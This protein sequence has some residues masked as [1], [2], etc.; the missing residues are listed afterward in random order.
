MSEK[1]IRK[2]CSSV[3]KH[4][5]VLFAAAML[6]LSNLF[7]P[8]QA[9][10]DTVTTSDNL[11]GDLGGTV[12][13]TH[14][15]GIDNGQFWF[16]GAWHDL[17]EITPGGLTQEGP[18]KDLG[19]GW[20]IYYSPTLWEDGGFMVWRYHT[21]TYDGTEWNNPPLKF[22]F[23][24]VGHTAFGEKFDV[25]ISFDSVHAWKQRAHN[26]S[27]FSPFSIT[28]KYG[29]M[30]AAQ[31]ND[32]MG[33]KS[34]FTTQLVQHG[35]NTLINPNNEFNLM[36]WDIDQPVWNDNGSADYSSEWREGVHKV[37]GYKP[38][39]II[40]TD[41]QLAVTD[42]ATWFRSTRDD[43]SNVPTSKSTVIMK[44]NPQYTTEWRGYG[45]LTCLGYDSKV[46]VYPEWSDPVKSEEE[47]IKE[48]GE[49][50]TFDITQVFPYVSETNK[51]QSIVMTDMLDPALD[52]SQA[53]VEVYKDNINVT[54]N[55]TINISGQTV[56][57]TAKNT[58]HGYTE[59]KHI[60]RLTVPVSTTADISAYPLYGEYYKVPNQASVS[61]NN[62]TKQTNEVRVLVPLKV[63]G[64]VTIAAKKKLTGGV[65]LQQDQFS[66]T[67]T[68][69][70]GSVVGR[71][72]NNANGDISFAPLEFTRA[73]IGKTYRYVI[74][75]DQGSQEGI[76]YDTHKE[77]VSVSITD[78]GH[79]RV[80]V[81]AHYDADGAVF[82]NVFHTTQLGIL[83]QSSAADHKVLANAKFELYQDDGDGQYQEQ[84]DTQL[85]R[86]YRDSQLHD[87]ATDGM[88]ITDEHGVGRCYGLAV[89]KTYWLI[90]KEP[91]SGYTRDTN[92]HAI[93]VDSNGTVRT[94]TA[95]GTE[96]LPLV[97]G[98]ATIT[99]SN[100]P[101]Q[102]LPQLGGSGS[103]GIY[104]VGGSM[105]IAGALY[106]VSV[107]LKKNNFVLIG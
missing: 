55:W 58:G 2:A 14:E 67:L 8:V 49:T 75:E 102:A 48:V 97:D 72:T 63:A 44:A 7:M 78:A 28:K 47:Q 69:E 32:H 62:Q 13:V 18:Q 86:F 100:N 77:S 17:G 19:D 22:R 10:A 50:A 95:A 5:I 43:P 11:L 41:S 36:Y 40:S 30:T 70:D 25:I 85:A 4:S 76:S 98:I 3:R 99:L 9:F 31:S 27:W 57:A 89:G 65:E 54:N 105:L 84:N 83:K 39:A 1:L 34:I 103:W 37:S 80:T 46:K 64:N 88:V 91:P 33:T 81:V 12:Y 101:V 24:N 107:Q 29:L 42:N 38:E 61:I 93:M 56:T 90:E 53:V 51:A 21:L 60:F 92:A 52:A 79:G 16:N 87:I 68:K 66:F 73:D 96:E 71:A 15:P 26:A 20:K 6:L 45:C 82:T 59:G 104:I 23:N 35:T 94:I 106:L 74:S